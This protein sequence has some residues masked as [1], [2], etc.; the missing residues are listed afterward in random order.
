MLRQKMW[1]F[2]SL[3]WSRRSIRLR[4]GWNKF[5]LYVVSMAEGPIVRVLENM[6][7]PCRGQILSSWLRDIAD[8]GIELSYRPA[9]LHRLAGGHDNFM[10]QSAISPCQGLRIWPQYSTF[11]WA[12]RPRGNC[13]TQYSL[14]TNCSMWSCW[15]T[16]WN[17]SMLSGRDT[18]AD[19]W[20]LCDQVELL[21]PT[22][23]Q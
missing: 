9:R 1:N 6:C 4:C 10:P 11:R 22:T 18:S 2:F 21:V 5:T 12:R 7:G 13:V 16:S 8:Y 23:R 14:N 15:E 17:C 19:F 20:A 3:P